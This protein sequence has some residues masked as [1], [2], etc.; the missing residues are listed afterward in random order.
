MSDHVCG[1]SVSLAALKPCLNLYSKNNFYVKPVRYVVVPRAKVASPTND[2]YS[3]LPQV[4]VV[5]AKY[6]VT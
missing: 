1:D 2:N 4:V 6:E 5:N 3:L